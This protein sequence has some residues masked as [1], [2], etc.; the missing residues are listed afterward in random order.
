M[1]SFPLTASPSTVAFRIPPD[2]RG[3]ALD[4]V[5]TLN[6]GNVIDNRDVERYSVRHT[7]VRHHKL[8]NPTRR[9]RH[10]PYSSTDTSQMS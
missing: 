8:Y 6:L 5:E 4:D 10:Y 1:M 3:T 7:L 2:G 9:L